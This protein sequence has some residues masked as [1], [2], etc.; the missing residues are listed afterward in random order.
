MISSRSGHRGR[1]RGV[2]TGREHGQATVEFALV[3]PVVAL[4]IIGIVE[5][6]RLGALQVAVV[7]A[8]R[9][10]ARSAAVDPRQVV[11]RRAVEAVVADES[12]TVMMDVDDESPP[13]VTVQV[14]KSVRL[15][16]GLG[17]SSVD[18]KASST[19]AVESP[20]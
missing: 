20:S 7:D 8:A 9:S 15:L 1:G 4:L 17:W 10:G 3:L 11:A 2:D 19:M 6:A 18:L 16:P 5:V 12:V 13:L 14:T